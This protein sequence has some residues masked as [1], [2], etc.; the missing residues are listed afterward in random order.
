MNTGPYKRKPRHVLGGHPYQPA[1]EGGEEGGGQVAESAPR[2]SGK[3][4]FSQRPGS[5]KRL[6]GAARHFLQV[7]LST[8]GQSV[9]FLHVQALHA[10]LQANLLPSPRPKVHKER[11]IGQSICS[12]LWHKEGGQRRKRQGAP[13]TSEAGVHRGSALKHLAP[14]PLSCAHGSCRNS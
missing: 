5:W 7:L 4:R 13:C 12:S 9:G 14:E 10:E 11:A 8:P 3:H 1:P 6:P 2:S